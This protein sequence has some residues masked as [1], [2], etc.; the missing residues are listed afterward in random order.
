[1]K[2]GRTILP[3][4]RFTLLHT[5]LQG[6]TAVTG[7]FLVWM[8]PKSEYALYALTAQFISTLAVLSDSGVGASALALAG[9]RWPDP[10]AVASVVVSAVRFRRGLIAAYGVVLV[11][12]MLWLFAKQE[13]PLY[14]SILLIALIL[15]IAFFQLNVNVLGTVPRLSG[16]F[17][18]AQRADVVGAALRMLVL[19]LLGT[20][21]PRFGL[22][23]ITV[24][25]A[26]LLGT[27]VTVASLQRSVRRRLDLPEHAAKQDIKEIGELTR[28]QMA[29]A[30]FY[31]VQ[32]QIAIW[33]VAVAGNTTAIADIGALSRLAVAFNA[34]TAAMTL[35]IV[36]RIS[37][38]RTHA[39]LMKHTGA[40][41]AI[42]FTFSCAMLVAA[43]QFPSALLLVLGPK[44]NNL[45]RE[46]FY[47]VLVSVLASTISTLWLIISS[48]GWV[49]H[50]WINI[51]LVIA[52]QI[53]AASRMQL[54][55]VKDVLQFNAIST[56]PTLL[57]YSWF[58]LEGIRRSHRLQTVVA[59]PVES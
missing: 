13:T 6:I 12:I 50:S 7:I 48:R 19:V 23:I 49:K 44:Y 38:S 18:E 34:V 51:P 52:V 32:G 39:E 54:T 2:I 10:R 1:M 59:V 33:I 41:F 24:T 47:I 43:W 9:R 55:S 37:K 35:I 56:V 16:D 26:A 27:S 11:P 57:L 28:S 45:Q 15:L 30:L 21:L 20:A 36:P 14:L 58:L 42:Q 22:N 53:I 25:L 46:V 40:A 3:V 5:A 17:H 4:A 8:L 29:G 31:C